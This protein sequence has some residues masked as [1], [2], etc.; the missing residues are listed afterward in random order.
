ML[1]AYLDGELTAKDQQRV[2]AHLS[3]CDA[4]AEELRTLQYTKV[5]LVKVPV[6]RIPR[7]FVVRRAD[8]ETP[9]AAA[10]RR[11]FGIG[12]RLAYGYLRGATALVTVAFALVVAGD[13]IGQLG[14]GG[15]QPATAPVEEAYVAEKEIVVEVTKVVQKAV[16][17]PV[18]VKDTPVAEV[19]KVVEK[20]ME[21]APTPSPT[22]RQVSPTASPPVREMEK[23][24]VQSLAVPEAVPTQAATAEDSL[25]TETIAVEEVYSAGETSTPAPIPT[26]TPPTPAPLPLTPTSPPRVT[27]EIVSTAPPRE[28]A[29]SL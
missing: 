10:S 6:P 26:V 20:A 21:P 16:E 2:E 23:E 7:S 27:P 3:H 11:R 12:S 1:S 14:F 18:V 28:S 25:P 4:C 15:R 19:E 24:G 13:L 22:R 8:L 9:A 17:E 29:N 5:L